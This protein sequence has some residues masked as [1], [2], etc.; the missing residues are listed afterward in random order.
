MPLSTFPSMCCLWKANHTYSSVL[1]RREKS[2]SSPAVLSWT[3][4][5]WFF[6]SLAPAVQTGS[7]WSCSL[8]RHFDILSGANTPEWHNARL[9]WSLFVLNLWHCKQAFHP[10]VT[11][12]TMETKRGNVPLHQQSGTTMLWDR[13]VSFV[14][15]RGLCTVG[16]DEVIIK[17]L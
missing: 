11:M 14:T 15:L 8:S 13:G 1:T 16:V 3:P 10:F 17:V 6:S 2:S 9:Y 12:V 7:A 4:E 5:L